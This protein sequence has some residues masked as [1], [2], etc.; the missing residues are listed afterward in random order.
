MAGLMTRVAPV[1]LLSVLGLQGQ[2]TP[3]AIVNVT[4]V[5][6]DHDGI[7]EHQTV[8][9]QDGRIKVVGPSRSLRLP[10]GSQQIDGRGKFLMPGLAD[11]HV[12][13]VREAL[14]Q[15]APSLTPS[16]SGRTAGIPA[17][18]SS[19]HERENTA[20]ALMFLANGITTVRNM[21]GSETIDAFAKEIDSG[22]VPGPHVYSTGP[23]TDGNPPSWQ[24]VRIVETSAQAEEAVRSDKKRGYVAIK[25][26]S[27]LSSD[28]YAAIV[29]A[30]RH[31]GLPVVGHVPWSVG[32]EGVLAAHQDSI[33]HL[34]GF[35]PS[36]Q[37]DGPGA[38]GK[39]FAD[40]IRDADLAKLPAIA[41]AIKAANSWVCPTLVVNDLP[42][43]DPTWLDQAS[44]VPPAVF[45]R[46]RTM[47]PSKNIDPRTTPRGYAVDLAIV[48]ALHRG[49][50]HLLLGTDTVKPGSLPGFSLHE[51]LEKFVAAGMTPYEAIRA[52]TVDAAE[53]LSQGEEFG[54]VT[55]GRRADLLLL[56]ANPLEDVKNTSKIAGVMASGRW[57]TAEELTHRLET[58]RS[59][60]QQ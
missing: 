27:R 48:T 45:D 24:S 50:V 33:E 22:R 4:V 14:P 21:W 32:L 10:S 29:A 6:M 56:N 57:L 26:Y 53:F 25:V 60:Y 8:V 31:E 41:Q 15:N 52:G 11:M 18:A 9:V 13:F 39:S 47:Y 42:R 20:Y 55:V 23:I 51:E 3:T 44:Y 37:P 54:V 58:L 1:L 36:L 59:S 12:H 34:D 40:L 46:Y 17:S 28:A 49:G 7:A 16:S 35:L 5:P 38:R 19:D 30:A 43:T 2:Q